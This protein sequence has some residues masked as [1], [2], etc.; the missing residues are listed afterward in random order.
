MKHKHHIIPKHMGGTDDESNLVE[1]TIE[2]HAEAHRKLYEEHGKLEDYL[3]W[4]G[5][6]GQIGKSEILSEIYKQNG[7][8][9][10]KRNIG[11]PAWNKGLTKEDPRVKPYTE[12]LKVAKTEEHK[13]AMRKQKSDSSNMGK[14]V[15]TSDT[16]SKLSEAAKTQFTPEAR[17][18]HSEIMKRRK[19]CQYCGME[20]NASNVTRHEKLCKLRITSDSID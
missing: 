10:G 2:E 18:A 9:R 17:I 13:S 3:A 1:L 5:L 4:K 16:K 14:Y 12:K 8:N 20:S 7:K 6:S 11:K 19:A 15:R